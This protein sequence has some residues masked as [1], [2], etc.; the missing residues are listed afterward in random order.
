[1]A[2]VPEVDFK[3]SLE[4]I[5]KY[6]LRRLEKKSYFNQEKNVSS[7]SNGDARKALTLPKE[8]MHPLIKKWEN[9]G[10]ATEK[11]GFLLISPFWRDKGGCLYTSSKGSL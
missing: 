3:M 6:F 10:I 5:D 11:R 8:V 9:E 1:L 2:N 7:I 4:L